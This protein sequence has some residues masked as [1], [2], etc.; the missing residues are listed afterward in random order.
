MEGIS[1]LQV[2]I[3]ANRDDHYS[4]FLLNKSLRLWLAFCDMPTIAQRGREPGNKATSKVQSLLWTTCSHNVWRV[5]TFFH[6]ICFHLSFNQPFVR[7]KY[8]INVLCEMNPDQRGMM[9]LP[10]PLQEAPTEGG[11]CHC[12]NRWWIQ[13]PVRAGAAD[14]T[15]NHIFSSPYK[16]FCFHLSS[17]RT[18][19]IFWACH[20]CNT[21]AA[22]I[23]SL[24]P[25]FHI[26]IKLCSHG[27][28][29]D[30][31]IFYKNTTAKWQKCHN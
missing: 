15:T 13:L 9:P 27:T 4:P 22:S 29:I 25:H 24:V 14:E 2:L 30:I 28:E 8:L 10:R 11:R 20:H 19:I 23:S 5:E 18:G 26:Y 1:A 3:Q 6:V 12:Y 16:E 31:F 7:V 17:M 21:K